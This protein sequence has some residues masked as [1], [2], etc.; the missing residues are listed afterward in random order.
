VDVAHLPLIE[1]PSSESGGWLAVVLSGDGGWAAGDRGMADA[2]GQAGVAVVGLDVRSYLTT[3]RT[4]AVAAG[5]LGLLLDHYL[6]MWGKDRVLLIG[7][8]HGA[9]IAPFLVSRLDPE[10]R[11]RIGL[12]ALVGLEDHASFQFHVSDLVTEIHRPG[13]LP[14]LPEVEK[15]SGL[16]MLCVSGEHESGS[17]CRSLG[18]PVA[19]VSQHLGGHHLT[20]TQGA[21]VARLILT[22]ARDLTS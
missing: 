1:R 18:P 11:R 2:L 20:G 13:D 4:P 6:R 7:Y 9:D 17:P 3:P 12:L 8:S 19:R 21:A 14:T 10:L 15:L 22:T 16:P 5:D